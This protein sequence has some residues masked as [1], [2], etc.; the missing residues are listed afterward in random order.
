MSFVANDAELN[1][2]I[3][4]LDDRPIASWAA[5]LCLIEISA[6][7]TTKAS[8]SEEPAKGTYPSTTEVTRPSNPLIRINMYL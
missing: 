2:L 3:F 6:K 7:M 8:R 1:Q 5:D 4:W